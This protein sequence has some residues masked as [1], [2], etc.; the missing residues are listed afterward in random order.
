MGDTLRRLLGHLLPARPLRDAERDAQLALHD[1]RLDA[2]T[3]DQREIEARLDL[4]EWQ[5]RRHG[6][7]R[8]DR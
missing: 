4:L 2:L 5:A 3:N 8:D 6:R 7:V 1:R